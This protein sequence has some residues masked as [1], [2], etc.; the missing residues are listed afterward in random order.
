ML[1]NAGD[2]TELYSAKEHIA[3]DDTKNDRSKHKT[4]NKNANDTT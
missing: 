3:N 4:G 1:A 2:K